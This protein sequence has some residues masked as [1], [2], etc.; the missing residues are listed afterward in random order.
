[1]ERPRHHGSLLAGMAL[2][3]G[4]LWGSNAWASSTGAFLDNIPN[5]NVFTCLNCHTDMLG[6]TLNSFGSDVLPLLSGPADAAGTTF[7]WT[8]AL[9]Q[10]DSDGDGQTNGQELGDPCCTWV[11]GQ[12]E[13]RT[14]AISNPSDAAG[15]SSDPNTPSCAA[16]PADGG[17]SGGGCAMVGSAV[18]LSGSAVALVVMALA[19][20]GPLRRR[21][22]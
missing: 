10:K 11:A 14:S 15:K 19:A 7:E 17:D 13:P 8:K 3:G 16:P 20:G 21:R 5:G 9:C 4:L 6:P 1:M 12:S 22:R 18:G 2:A